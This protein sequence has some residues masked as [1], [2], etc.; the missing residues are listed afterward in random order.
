VVI[1]LNAALPAVRTGSIT[2]TG[3]CGVR[4]I[5]TDRFWCRRSFPVVVAIGSYVPRHGVRF[6][7]RPTQSRPFTVA[8]MTFG[9]RQKLPIGDA[10]RQAPA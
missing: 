9:F 5:R 2:A 6:R 3:Q 10:W 7:Q 1:I 8:A 4:I